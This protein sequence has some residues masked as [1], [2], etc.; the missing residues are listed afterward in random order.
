MNLTFLKLKRY[1]EV[2]IGS[3]FI[4]GDFEICRRWSHDSMI[5]NCPLVAVK[6]TDLSKAISLN[7]LTFELENKQ[8]L[9]EK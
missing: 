2:S 8:A 5:S 9:E 7:I 1:L 3:V 4:T 6:F